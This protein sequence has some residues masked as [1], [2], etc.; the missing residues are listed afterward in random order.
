MSVTDTKLK[1]GRIVAIAG[2]VVDVESTPPSWPRSPS[3][4]VTAES[5]PLP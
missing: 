5:A 1:D 4:L 2:P 3:R